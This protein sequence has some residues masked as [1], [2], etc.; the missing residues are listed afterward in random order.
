[1]NAR[2]RAPAPAPVTHG[3]LELLG[4]GTSS[5]VPLIGC[6]CPTCT[7]TDPRDQRL[8][9]SAVLRF[10]DPAGIDRVVLIDVSPD[11]RTQALKSGITRCDGILITHSH[12]DHVWGLD[13]VRRY[14]A[15]MQSPIDLYADTSTLADLGR[16]Y[17]HIFEP[18]RNINNSF[19]ANLIAHRVTPG[20]SIALHG[21]RLTP[22]TVL[23]GRSPVLAWRIET[24]DG[25]DGGGV[26]P[27]AYC[28]DVSGF[29]P[30]AYTHLRGLRVLVL[31]MLRFRAH[32]THFTVDQSVAH[33]A[34]IAAARTVFVHMT[35]NIRHAELDPRLPASM[36]LGFDG[37]RLP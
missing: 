7:S 18:S 25:G 10:R 37:L 23:H 28:T 8:R 17:E 20:V 30:D 13:E 34:E 27:L 14:N 6:A 26:F 21:L 31:D 29:P 35:H 33:A 2:P 4:T 5:G 3:E 19:V 12:V 9:T 32:P 11:H 15:L 36:S 22:F 1:M 16:V 24:I